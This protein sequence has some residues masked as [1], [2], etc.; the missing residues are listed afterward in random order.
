MLFEPTESGGFAKSAA[1]LTKLHAGAG[2]PFV[3]RRRGCCYCRGD[4]M[5][6]GCLPAWSAAR[7]HQKFKASGIDA[8]SRWDRLSGRGRIEPHRSGSNSIF[9]DETDTTPKMGASLR[10]SA[11][12]ASAAA[13]PSLRPSGFI[14]RYRAGASARVRVRSCSRQALL[15][16]RCQQAGLTSFAC[17]FSY[18]QPGD[19]DSTKSAITFQRAVIY[20]KLVIRP[21]ER[22]GAFGDFP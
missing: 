2:G 12:N 19:R 10:Q 8:P 5:P 6:A 15:A 3:L 21:T 1:G 22:S 4:V 17:R 11:P 18:G 9:I 16:H 7:W 20:Q 14:L 13:P